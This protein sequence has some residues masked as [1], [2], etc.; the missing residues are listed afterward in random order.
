ME[1]KMKIYH[2]SIKKIYLM[3]GWGTVISM[4]AIASILYWAT[5][6]E[7]ALW[8]GAVLSA[9]AVGNGYLNDGNCLHFILG[10][11]K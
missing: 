1:I 7:V 2:L 4:M 11:R 5:G 9:C 6:S 10:D 8:C 3:I